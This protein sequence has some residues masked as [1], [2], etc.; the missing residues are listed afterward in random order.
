MKLHEF[1]PVGETPYPRAIHRDESFV[2][3]CAACGCRLTPRE[4]LA[5]GGLLGPDA[6]WRHFW[7]LPGRD[8]RGCRVECID[9]PHRITPLEAAA[10]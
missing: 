3:T 9:M 4:S 8:A 2:L 5:D 10:G 1:E 7:G 6:A